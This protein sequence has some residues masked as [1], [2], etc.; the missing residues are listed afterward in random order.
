M[1]LIDFFTKFNKR[2]NSNPNYIF[3]PSVEFYLARLDSTEYI[4]TYYYCN[5]PKVNKLLIIKFNL[6]K[7]INIPILFKTSVIN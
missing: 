2:I 6:N 7:I 3:N 5:I 4:I 1:Y